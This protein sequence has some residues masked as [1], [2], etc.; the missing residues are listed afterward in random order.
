VV[1]GPALQGQDRVG[2]PLGAFAGRHRVVS[3]RHP[4]LLGQTDPVGDLADAI[5]VGDGD[6]PSL[7]KAVTQKNRL[8]LGARSN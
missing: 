8:V 3:R 1:L 2:G 4:D 7:V 5:A 6:V